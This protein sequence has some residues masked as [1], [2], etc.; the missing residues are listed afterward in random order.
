MTNVNEN[1]I[2]I[3][4]CPICN[5]DYDR[6][7]EKYNCNNDNCNYKMCDTC[8]NTYKKSHDICAF[9][10]SDLDISD[11]DIITIAINE[12]D[13]PDVI[14]QDITNRTIEYIKKNQNCLFL[15]GILIII[16]YICFIIFLIFYD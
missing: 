6:I 14:R 3:F 10:R 13:P 15:I 2:I 5:N 1:S 4:E 11:T 12:N 7:P 9:C 16:Y 8:L